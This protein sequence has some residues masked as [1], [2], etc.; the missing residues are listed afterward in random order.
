MKRCVL[1]T[2]LPINST[3]NSKLDMSRKK[4]NDHCLIFWIQVRLGSYEKNALLIVLHIFKGRNL[5]LLWSQR[6]KNQ[7]F[8]IQ[9]YLI[10]VHVIGY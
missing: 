9:N 5:S 4:E 6:D 10:N 8:Y 1:S 3:N 2:F 7:K